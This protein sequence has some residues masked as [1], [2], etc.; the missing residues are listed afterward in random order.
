ML[1]S[2]SS[3]Y[4]SNK[5]AYLYFSFNTKLKAQRRIV[6][7]AAL[8][9]FIFKSSTL[10]IL[11]R[12]DQYFNYMIHLNFLPFRVAKISRKKN[13]VVI[14]MFLSL[15]KASISFTHNYRTVLSMRYIRPMLM[16]VYL[17][18]RIILLGVSPK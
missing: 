6:S 18:L 10:G 9:V 12:S 3:I 15:Y 1:L 17:A 7:Y 8:S 5:L 13:R 14:K 16:F 4:M 2:S 11:F